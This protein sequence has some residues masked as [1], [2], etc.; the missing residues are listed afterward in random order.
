VSLQLADVIS[1]WSQG[2]SL[3]FFLLASL[4]LHSGANAVER[5]EFTRPTETRTPI[6]MWLSCTAEHSHMCICAVHTR[7]DLKIQASHFLPGKCLISWAALQEV[8]T[9]LTLNEVE[10]VCHW[11]TKLYQFICGKDFSVL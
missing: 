11:L 2:P 9:L 1:S 4:L 3:P 6:A 5:L 10:T 7:E 8:S